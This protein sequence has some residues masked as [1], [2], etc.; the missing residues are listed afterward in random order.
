MSDEK[1]KAKMEQVTGSVKESLGKLS[2]DKSLETEGKVNKTT[3]KVDEVAADAK[4]A[5]DGLAKGLKNKTKE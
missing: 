3:G 2:G 4:D 1:L 5:L